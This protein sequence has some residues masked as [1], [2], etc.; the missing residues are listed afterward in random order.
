M[1]DA[2]YWISRALEREA[3]T[4]R[5]SASL[6][7]QVTA[8]YEKALRSLDADIRQIIR[9]YAK[10][11]KMTEAEALK[12]LTARE[13][14]QVIEELK[15]QIHTITDADE[16]RRLL[17][18][19][20]APAYRARITR[21]QALQDRV[22]V[23][24]SRIAQERIQLEREQYIRT[25]T[26]E[27]HR[28]L[29][30][31]QVASGYGF[32]FAAVPERAIKAAIDHKWSGKNYSDTV[33][34]D[35]HELAKQAKEIVQQGLFTGKSVGRMRSE[36]MNRFVVAEWKA[37]RVIRTEMNF[38]HNQGDL[39]GYRESG[40]EKYRYLATL[41]VRTCAK[42]GTL[43][44]MVIAVEDAEV[45]TN[46]PPLHP[47]DRCT[48]VAY[49][50]DMDTAGMKRR[51]RDPKT[52]ETVLVPRDMTYTEWKKLMDETYG[53]GFVDTTRKKRYNV[54]ADREQYKRYK[55]VLGSNAPQTFEEFQQVK[56]GGD[57]GQLKRQYADGCIQ[58]RIK[59]GKISTTV[60][61]G[62][63]GKH[64]RGHNNYT[65]G[66]S[67]INDG[68]DVQPLVDLYAGT[69][70]ILR[71]ACGRWSH[72]E[73]VVADMVIGYDVSIVD[74]TETPTKFFTIHYSKKGV[75][76]VPT[77]ED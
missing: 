70:E 49:F 73:K 16:R 77:K 58:L 22:E 66:R 32:E 62:K 71:D 48:T 64:I 63:Q 7:G 1:S 6:T 40:I 68:I 20:E 76:I 19:I 18:R 26:D 51:A 5:R 61:E 37:G 67:Y 14:N 29:Y 60:L 72:K 75:H 3:R 24:V 10:S 41:D 74:G 53:T 17:A 31:I 25:L 38:F 21:L 34:D 8:L 9:A 59:A 47:N 12:R 69:G 30:E 54:N 4:A 2:A 36:L 52:G 65:E 57:Y 46:Y 33:W 39:A 43:D 35:T 28:S 13:S 50:D 15:R 45:G 23:T 55:A 56:Y 44:N 27:Y 11:G 42:C